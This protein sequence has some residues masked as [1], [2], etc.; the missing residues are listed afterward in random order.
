MDITPW[1]RGLWHQMAHRRPMATGYATRTPRRIWDG[2]RTDP[3][4]GPLLA[5]QFGGTTPVRVPPD[6]ARRV[7]A[8]HRIRFII[9]EEAQ[10]NVLAALD[11]P[12]RH[13]GDGIVIYEID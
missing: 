6:E 13:R 11:L 4:L 12:E 5:A 7:L 8:H 9:A 10:T 3:V 1:S 2:V